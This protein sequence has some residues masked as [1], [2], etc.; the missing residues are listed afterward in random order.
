MSAIKIAGLHSVYSGQPAKI[1]GFYYLKMKERIDIEGKLASS[2][3]DSQQWN[4]STKP[5]FLPLEALVR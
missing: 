3:V 2:A 4:S 1:H 5:Q